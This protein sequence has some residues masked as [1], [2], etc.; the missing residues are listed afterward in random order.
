MPV[1]SRMHVPGEVLEK[2]LGWPASDGAEVTMLDTGVPGVDLFFCTMGGVPI[3]FMEPMCPKRTPMPA[4]R[5][6][7]ECEVVTLDA[8]P[9]RVRA[10]PRGRQDL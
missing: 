6:T 3:E 5:R 7:P 10:A 9:H 2:T 8:V 4:K 1:Q